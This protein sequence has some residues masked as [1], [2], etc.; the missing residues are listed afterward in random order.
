MVFKLARSVCV[1]QRQDHW[2]LHPGTSFH[3]DMDGEE[4]CFTINAMLDVDGDFDT[5]AKSSN[6]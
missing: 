3:F 2:D 6:V 1:H 4:Y 5:E